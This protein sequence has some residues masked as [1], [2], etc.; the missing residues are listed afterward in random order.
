MLVIKNKKIAFI[1]AVLI[2]ALF[3]PSASYA[4]AYGTADTITYSVE[5][6]E[7]IDFDED[8]F[9][10][11]CDDL[12]GE[13]LD[14][15]KFTLPSSDYG[16]LYYDF[17]TKSN[18]DKV[19]ASKKYYYDY[20]PY[21][22]KITFVPDEDYEGTV[23]IN[24][25]GYD[26][27]G[28]SF[29][30]KVKITVTDAGGGTADDINY[31]VDSNKTLDF[32]EDDFNDACEDVKRD[33]LDYVKFTL[34]SSSDGILYYDYKSK[35]NYYSKVTATAKYYY[36]DTPALSRV[37]FV[38]DKDSDGTVTIKYTGYDT[39]GDSF[40]GK[41][42]ISVDEST[43]NEINYSIDKD[44]IVTFDEDDFYEICD[45]LND[46]ALDYVTFTLPASTK[47]VLY[48]N[49]DEDDGDYDSKITASKNYYY[50]ESPYLSKIT[51]VP[52]DKFS[53]ECTISFKGYDVSGDSFTGTVTISVKG[54]LS[55][56]ET[57]TYTA[58]T[59]SSVYFKEDD[60]N[61]VCKKLMK[62]SLE[63]VKFTLPS[64]SS[65]KLYYGYTSSGTYT[66]E[67]STSSKYYY[68]STPF[69]LNVAFVPAS[70]ASGTTAIEYTGYD[71]QGFAYTGKVQITISASGTATG[72]AVYTNLKK[73]QYFSD[74]D[75]AY[76]WAVDYVDTLYT[77][78]VITGSTGEDNTKHFYPSS[79]ITRGDFILFLTRALNLQT[80][81]SAGNFTDVTQGS[82]Y[83]EAIA[84]AK[85]MGIALG[86]ENKF[87]PNASITR[88]DAM[89][90]A[91]RAMN[92]SGSG[93]AAGDI[94][95]LSAYSD[96]NVI[97]DYAQ[98][99]VAALIKAGIITGSDDNKIH[100]MESM[101]RIQAIA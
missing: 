10:D 100:P 73:S 1:L 59:G 61:N 52:A 7:E 56:A 75:E 90:L 8:D 33:K 3:I 94:N 43:S 57:I 79:K 17:D 14:Y 31:S 82:Y 95:T 58:K 63:Y 89:V 9:N 78:G 6:D 87:Y 62:N 23:T 22:S 37:S 93:V 49:Y 18:S 72:S 12:T 84:T 68:G 4:T 13:D 48:Y 41:I 54:T 53:G 97:S 26:T 60:F 30:G 77:S 91:L 24:Y 16:T 47:G 36:D 67:V 81:T 86:S 80:N 42:K 45:E 39:D 51:F 27:D 35:D 2:T 40:S 71:S 74:V 11:E 101:T 85:A 25:T 5:S 99:A 15:V 55:S 96:K 44:E 46:E 98:E 21:L 70:N 65:G 76:S 32:D 20:S 88:E 34:P 83:Y 50:D 92:K 66:S 38:P 19:I 69:L 28:N 64:S 29:T